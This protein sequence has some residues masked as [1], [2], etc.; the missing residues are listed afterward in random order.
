MGKEIVKKPSVLELMATKYNLDQ[1]TFLNTIKATVIK[2]GRDGKIASNE[3]IAAF[4]MVANKYNLDPFTNEIYAFPSKGGGIVPIVGVDGFVTIM[5]RQPDYNGYE[6]TYSDEDKT[7]DGGK[8]CP[9]WAEVKIYHKDRDHATIVR[10]YL[11]EVYVPARNNYP[12]PWQS[13]TK[14]MLRHKVLI[15][16]IRVAF[17]ITGI[18][19]PDEGDRILDAQVIDS[20]N[21]TG[22]PA[23]QQKKIL[24]P[25]SPTPEIAQQENKPTGDLVNHFIGEIEK[26]TTKT[27]L[28]QL[29]EE[30]KPEASKPSKSDKDKLNDSF[31]V[32]RKVIQKK[33]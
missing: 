6:M 18:Y 15:Q 5:N 8:S 31:A 11:D 27:D 4:L 30:I 13:H 21:N 20:K 16:G 19:D 23:P 1:V 2:P 17:G 32:T 9:E 25:N 28:D 26:C 7:M 10:E 22:I 3:E 12:G 14:R 33:K 24:P 29:A